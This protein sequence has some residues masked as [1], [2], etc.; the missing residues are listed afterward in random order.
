MRYFW[1]LF[2]LVKSYEQQKHTLYNS[3]SAVLWQLCAPS[4]SFF[5]QPNLQ[6]VRM[7]VI[8]KRKDSFFRCFK[9]NHLF[10]R[11]QE[12]LFAHMIVKF[13]LFS[14]ANRRLSKFDFFSWWV[15]LG[16]ESPIQALIWKFAQHID[17]I[18]ILTWFDE[19]DG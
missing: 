5:W 2:K 9:K 3:F 16:D 8:W 14:A 10:C 4:I 1:N 17:D 18:L 15:L 11:W 6:L 7:A 13:F 19:D 12:K